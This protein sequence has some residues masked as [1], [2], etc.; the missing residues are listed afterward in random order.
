MTGGHS[1]TGTSLKRESGK[2]LRGWSARVAR[3]AQ[4]ARSPVRIHEALLRRRFRA[5]GL[6]EE[7]VVLGNGSVHC[8]HGGQSAGTP[9][10]L[11][12]GFGASALWQ[13]Y[14]QVPFLARRFKL[15]LPDLVFFGESTSHKGDRSVRFQAETLLQLATH[16]GLDRFQAVGLSYGGFVALTLA[17]LAPERVDRI[18]LV[19]SPGYTMGAEDHR[20]ILERFGVDHVRDL[21]L[22]SG[23]EGVERLLRI[24]WHRPPWV[25]GFVL[26]DTYHTLFRGRA[27][28]HAELLERLLEEFR[29]GPVSVGSLSG[30]AADGMK[31]R[32]ALIL[33]GE[34]DPIFPPYLARRLQEHL[35]GTARLRII[36][37]TAH[38]PNM[39]KPALFNRLLAEFLAG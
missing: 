5:A 35:G 13:W 19:G 15:Y 12:H 24:A 22:P 26:R 10:L 17:D 32:Q 28:Q 16:V 7:R 38:A 37:D 27:Q 25:P 2:G 23:P 4:V 34:H 31:P 39:E 18:C 1:N 29:R 33:W 6:V 3:A 20:Q 8:W 11:L 21:L 9:V 14:P 36:K 30:R